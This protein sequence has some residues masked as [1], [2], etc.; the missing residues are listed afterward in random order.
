MNASALLPHLVWVN[1]DLHCLL[2]MIELECAQE[3]PHIQLIDKVA[4]R[5]ENFNKCLGI[6]S[7]DLNRRYLMTRLSLQVVCL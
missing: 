6:R 3:V 2:S 4:E 1:F 5:K 7:V